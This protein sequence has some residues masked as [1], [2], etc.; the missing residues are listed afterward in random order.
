[1]VSS[2]LHLERDGD[3][4]VLTIRREAKRN[5]LDG[6]LWTAL[7]EAAELITRDAIPPRAVILT[8]AGGHFCAGMDLSFDNPLIHR[9]LP[10]LQA[11][12]AGAL[13][14][15]VLE[16][17]AVPEAI[18]RIPCPVIG[19]I[20]GACTGGGLELALACD[21]RVAGEDAFFSLPETRVGMMPDVGGTVRA[22]R[23]LGRSRAT[24]LVVAGRR[25]SAGEALSWGLVTRVAP[26]GDALA[27]A[28]SLARELAANAPGASRHALGVLRE[29][30]GLDDDTAFARETEAGVRT[31]LGGECL[32]GVQAFVER[33]PPR[34]GSGT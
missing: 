21:L 7:R 26:K 5:A 15:L 25:L 14:D 6:P 19:A 8:G 34:W 28:R 23:L 11:G 17:K 16:L 9:L 32:E 20:E 3:V 31:L 2:N 12:D 1:M 33:R 22:V 27:A 30:D 18:S 29:A 13:R 24:E 4:S 10:A